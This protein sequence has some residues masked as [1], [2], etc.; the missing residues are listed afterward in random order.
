MCLGKPGT[1]DGNAEG[2]SGVFETLVFE[3]KDVE[4][5]FVSKVRTDPF[6]PRFSTQRRDIHL[7]GLR[8]IADAPK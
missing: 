4:V 8:L 7:G 6:P 1:L 3:L 2:G 5:E